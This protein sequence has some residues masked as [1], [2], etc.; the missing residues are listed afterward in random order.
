MKVHAVYELHS[1]EVFQP[2]L[3]CLKPQT[4]Y[5][6]YDVHETD[7]AFFQTNTITLIKYSFEFFRD[8]FFV[9]IF[10]LLSII[11]KSKWHTINAIYSILLVDFWKTHFY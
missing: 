11:V 6:Q 9:T 5:D 8:L 7:K 1:S 2:K 10:E 4:L 3:L